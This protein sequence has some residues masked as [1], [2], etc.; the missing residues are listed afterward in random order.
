MLIMAWHLRC[1]VVSRFRTNLRGS[2]LSLKFCRAV[3]ALLTA[4]MLEPPLLL[5]EREET[6]KKSLSPPRLKQ[7]TTP[8]G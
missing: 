4:R 2:Y 1:P 6:G 8:R 5:V 7:G 3:L